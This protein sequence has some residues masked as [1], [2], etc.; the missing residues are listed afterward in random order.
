MFVSNL[1]LGSLFILTVFIYYMSTIKL[2]VPYEI[3]GIKA[4][5]LNRSCFANLVLDFA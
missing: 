1:S 2:R 3:L 5:S 4:D